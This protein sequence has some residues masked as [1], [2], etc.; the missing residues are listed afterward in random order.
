MT[1]ARGQ[2]AQ[3]MDPVASQ[4]WRGSRGH[5]PRRSALSRA[6]EVRTSP[7]TL[8]LCSACDDRP[9]ARRATVFRLYLSVC[10]C[11]VCA[12]G[13]M[14]AMGAILSFTKY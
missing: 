10:V 13:Q 6:D 4:A 7:Q 11:G 12:N 8:G 9:L 1:Q 14:Y 3:Q 2:Q 5:A